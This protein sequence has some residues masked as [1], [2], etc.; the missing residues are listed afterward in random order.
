MK[1]CLLIPAVMALLLDCSVYA[2]QKKKVADRIDAPME[3]DVRTAQWRPV[4]PTP[5]IPKYEPNRTL[6]K[7]V[8]HSWRW[9][10]MQPVRFLVMA[11]KI[12]TIPLGFA[13]CLYVVGSEN[14]AGRPMAMP[15][16]RPAFENFDPLPAIERDLEIIEARRA[17]R[18]SLPPLKMHTEL[19]PMRVSSAAKP[20]T[21]PK[22]VS[23]TRSMISIPLGMS[24]APVIVCQLGQSAYERDSGMSPMLDVVKKGAA[25]ERLVALK[26]PVLGKGETVSLHWALDVSGAKRDAGKAGATVGELALSK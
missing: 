26:K 1:T 13:G 25:T 18:N 6:A 16:F 21:A 20:V 12:P 5:V 15:D 3:Y 23:S 10:A 24:Q 11:A 17:S 22:I 8:N 2:A 4:R 9:W 19:Q 14:A 7:P